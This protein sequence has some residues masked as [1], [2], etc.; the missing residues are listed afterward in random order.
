MGILALIAEFE[1]DI[2]RERQMDGIKKAHER[3]VRFGRKPL[4]VDEMIKRSEEA[5][6][7]W[8]NSAGNHAADTA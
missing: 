6:E 1:N 8:R 2:R 7:G 4:L 3:G 5:E